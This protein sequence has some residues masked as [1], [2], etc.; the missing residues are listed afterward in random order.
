[1]PGEATLALYNQSDNKVYF[2]PSEKHRQGFIVTCRS[3]N[4]KGLLLEDSFEVPSTIC[5]TFEI[6]LNIVLIKQQKL[7]LKQQM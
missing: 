3:S 5:K 7:S 2:S 4:N 6:I 1:V